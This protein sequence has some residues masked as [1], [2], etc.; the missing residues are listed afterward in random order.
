M[1]KL[2]AKRT[3]IKRRIRE[4]EADHE[5]LLNLL[6][7]IEQQIVTLEMSSTLESDLPEINITLNDEAVAMVNVGGRVRLSKLRDK[8][9]SWRR[10]IELDE[11]EREITL[12]KQGF[13]IERKAGVWY[14]RRVKQC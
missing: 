4:N 13:E 3:A 6:R 9:R 10:V 2:I 12:N 14:A 11:W 7:D 1:R 8:S 5:D